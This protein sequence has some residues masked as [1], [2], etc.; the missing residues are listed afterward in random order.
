MRFLYGAGLLFALAGAVLCDDIKS[1][2]GVLVLNKDN[3]E[4]ATADNEF[5]LVEF[6]A[7]WCGHC[8]ALAPEY[9]KAAK[10]LAEK[11]SPIKLAKVDATEEQELAERFGVRGYPT[12]KFFRNGTPL[13]YSG[14]RQALDIVAWLVKKTGPPAADLKSVGDVAALI[15][16][17]PIAVVG[18]FKDQSTDLAKQ[19]L[20]VAASVDDVPF[21]VVADDDVVANYEA[22]DQ[23][24]VLF[25]KFDEGRATYDGP[26][27]EKDIK[28][29]VQVNQLPLLVEFNHE[30]AQKVFGGEI[31]SHLLL[32]LNKNDE[33]AYARV[34]E[35][36]RSVAAPF[37]EQV[38]FVSIDANEEDH[39]RILE[40]FGMK[41]D[42]VPAARLIKLEE[43]MAK[44]KP[45]FVDL[46]ADNLKKFVGDFLDG[47]LKQHLLSQDLPADWDAKPLKTL[48]ASNFDDV[49]FDEAKDVL[50]EFYAPWCGHCKQ[51]API[52]EQVAE[53][54]KDNAGVAIAQMDSTANELETIKV[55]SFPTIKL[56]KKGDNHAVD[57]NGP[58][59]FDG[60]VKFVESGGKDGAD[61]DEPLEDTDEEAPA[62]DEL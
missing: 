60:I 9:E 3:F 22:A 37:R 24:I 35:A 15:D 29:F 1:E 28:K 53:H 20:A 40:F 41:K 45:D 55:T 49:A 47:K 31:K 44:Y 58:R 6:Y 38:L 10:T 39:Q 62:K 8:K 34:T 12:L 17:N 2:E 56:F 25:K 30:T 54:F 19:F 23:Q 42:E 61:A 5:I 46:T 43:D 48:V 51:L 18:F 16:A 36:A 21:G 13:E 26:A 4:K 7:P 33:E 32:F 57:Y 50:V 14:G 59:T 52:Y 11:E 27:V